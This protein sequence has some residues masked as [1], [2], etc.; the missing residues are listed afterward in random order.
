VAVLL[1]LQDFG[2][3][4]A[5]VVKRKEEMQRAQDEY[6]AY[7]AEHFRRG[8]MRQLTEEERQAIVDGLKENWEQLHRDYL[9]LSVVIDTVPK[10][11]RKE[12]LEADMKQL[13]RDVELFELHPAIYVANWTTGQ[14]LREDWIVAPGLNVCLSLTTIHSPIWCIDPNSLESSIKCDSS[15]HS[16]I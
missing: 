3:T 15:K 2:E 6:D 16:V 13:E 9:Q 14:S 4:P 8:A 7:V 1:L 11:H 5:Y 10:K 12:R